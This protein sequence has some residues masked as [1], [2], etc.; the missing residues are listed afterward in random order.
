MHCLGGCFVFFGTN[1]ILW[2]AALIDR[3][4]V[5]LRIVNLGI[6]RSLV[7]STW[8][9]VTYYV[10]VLAAV[11]E[12]VRTSLRNYCLGVKENNIDGS[13]VGVAVL[14][15]CSMRPVCIRVPV[16][17][18]RSSSAPRPPPPPSLFWFWP[19]SPPTAPPP[20]PPTARMALFTRITPG[21]ERRRQRES[22]SAR[23]LPTLT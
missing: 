17:L 21:Q 2:R 3:A 15:F 10:I 5:K 20:P 6:T 8:Y 11:Q 23:C 12:L 13:M 1:L 19:S 16:R 22:K 14:L 4:A 7:F 9:P 18:V